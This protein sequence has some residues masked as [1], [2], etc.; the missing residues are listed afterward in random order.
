[1]V[2]RGPSPQKQKRYAPSDAIVRFIEEKLELLK[3]DKSS[4]KWD[5]KKVYY[6]DRLFQS[7]A[8]LIYFLETTSTNSQL[9]DNFEDDLEELLDVRPYRIA[10][11]LHA[12]IGVKSGGFLPHTNLIRLIYASLIPYDKDY[13]NFRLK[14]LTQVQMLI[15]EKIWSIIRDEYG[16]ST[17]IAKSVMEDMKRSLGWVSMLSHP[18]DYEKENPSRV[19]NFRHPYKR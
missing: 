7:L 10:H 17:L 8:D 16:H 2:K 15:Y 13:K 1:M 14:L 6:L 19:I 3:N 5:S 9:R 12:V 4:R 11:G 18:K